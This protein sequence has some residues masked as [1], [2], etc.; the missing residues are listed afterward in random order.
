MT[1]NPTQ[2]KLLPIR[3]IKELKN[4][5]KLKQVIALRVYAVKY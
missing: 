3:F 1:N 4:E 5:W 2:A